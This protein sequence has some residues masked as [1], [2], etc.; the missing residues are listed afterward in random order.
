MFVLLKSQPRVTDQVK[1]FSAPGVSTSCLPASFTELAQ[2]FQGS[3][4]DK[5][6]GILLPEHALAEVGLV[7]GHP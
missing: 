3:Y 5:A 6:L 1:V 4:A 2:P 7:E